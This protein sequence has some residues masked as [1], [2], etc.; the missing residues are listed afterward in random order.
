MNEDQQDKEYLEKILR[1]LQIHKPEV[2]NEK[3]AKRYLA[4]MKKFAEEA[5]GEDLEFAELLLKAME[6]AKLRPEENAAA[7]EGANCE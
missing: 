2:A 1:Y 6:E 3:E 7:D 5:V 4:L